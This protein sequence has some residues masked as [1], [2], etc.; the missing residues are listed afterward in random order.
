VGLS[1]GL[2]GGY[3]RVMVNSIAFNLAALASLIPVALLPMRRSGGRDGVFWGLLALA[4]VGP[5]LWAV[6]QLSGSWR[7][8]L[9]AELWVG[10]AASMVLFAV[11]A[12]FHRQAWRLTPLLVPYMLLLGLFASVFAY[13]P[14][15]AL[16]ST[17]PP[18]WID[19]HIIVSVITVGLLT[20][21][22]SAALATFLQARALKTKRPNGL[23]RMLPP[24][25]D[26]ERLFERLLVVSELVLGL[27]VAT[28]MATQYS[29]NG[30]LLDFDHK[31]LLSLLAFV[32][33]G[34]LLIG[35]RV[36]GVRGQIAARTVL[37]AYSLVILGFFG[38]KFV[39]Q[40]LLS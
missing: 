24:V 34:S 19:T 33:I 25:S 36:C 11:I 10:I 18:G 23:T 1:G 30:H 27:G 8:N 14:P 7:T 28:G 29:E 20:V 5:L 12:A 21:A 13:A 31:T 9:S 16:A 35:R 39:K 22:A 37:I 3:S 38:V 26:S 15:E 4:I 2:G 32:I 6:G 40:V 17:A